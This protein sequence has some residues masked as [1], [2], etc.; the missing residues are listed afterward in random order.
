MKIFGE[1]TKVLEQLGE[2]ARRVLASIPGAA[3]VQ[4]EILS[5]VTELRVDA[6]LL[7]GPTAAC[8]HKCFMPQR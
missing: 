5:G 4:A 2:Q 8:S 6:D 3:D 1:D 7:L